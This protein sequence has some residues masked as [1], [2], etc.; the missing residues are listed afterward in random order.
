M[1]LTCVEQSIKLLKFPS[2]KQ[3]VLGSYLREPGE[4]VLASHEDSAD[5][6]REWLSGL[7]AKEGV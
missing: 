6:L 7:S 2:P 1:D 3:K 5:V 4:L